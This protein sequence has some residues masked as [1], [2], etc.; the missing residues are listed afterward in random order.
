MELVTLRNMTSRALPGFVDGAEY[1]LAPKGEDSFFPDVARELAAQWGNLVVQVAEMDGA[2]ADIKPK[3]PD[4]IY[5]ANMTGDPDAPPEVEVSGHVTNPTT[6]LKVARKELN[7]KASPRS[8]S[9]L[10]V[11]SQSSLRTRHGQSVGFQ[12]LKQRVVVPPYKRVRLPYEKAQ[13][14]LGRDRRRHVNLSGLVI[15]AR[16]P[17]NWEAD[18]SWD[19]D[20][21]R[22]YLRM[23]D[24]EVDV[25]PSEKEV[26]ADK[27]AIEVA[28]RNVWKRVFLR[29]VN[30]DFP[31]P[32]KQNFEAIR[33]R[34]N[35]GTGRI[36]AALEEEVEPSKPRQRPRSEPRITAE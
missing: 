36:E 22:C 9:A 1:T 19:L 34:F 21:L 30:R 26:G 4:F 16:E 24:H 3:K 2:D 31:L 8:V 17:T 13:L 33:A 25:G 35:D 27:R 20:D 15:E 28:K 12:A 5:V 23:M 29:M 18:P 11:P 6:G 14:I 32:T 10:Y 7:P